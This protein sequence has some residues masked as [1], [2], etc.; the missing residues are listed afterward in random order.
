MLITCYSHYNTFIVYDDQFN[1]LFKGVILK[2][3]FTL[4]LGYGIYF[5]QAN[6]NEADVIIKDSMFTCN[7]A[8]SGG[9]VDIRLYGCGS[10]KLSNSII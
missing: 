9:G 7:I 2:S 8:W 10:I 5:R 1:R 3:T 6:D 4:E